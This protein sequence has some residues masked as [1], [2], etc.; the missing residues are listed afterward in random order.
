MQFCV[1]TNSRKSPGGYALKTFHLKIILVM[2]LSD[3]REVYCNVRSTGS[4]HGRPSLLSC[5]CNEFE[6]LRV[7]GVSSGIIY[8]RIMEHV[9]ELPA[10]VSKSTSGEFRGCCTGFVKN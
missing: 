10:G 7:K 5:G 4:I 1:I 8:C 6:S 3:T 2:A 9:V